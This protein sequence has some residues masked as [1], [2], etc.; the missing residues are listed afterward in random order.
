MHRRSAVV[1]VVAAIAASLSIAWPATST[2]DDQGAVG[3]GRANAITRT[4]TS[5][6]ITDEVFD[7][8]GPE[9][10]GIDPAATVSPLRTAPIEDGAIA[11]STG[12]FG[13]QR[14]TPGGDFALPTDRTRWPD[15]TADIAGVRFDVKGG[16]VDVTIRFTSMPSRDA[17]IAT[18]TFAT[19][20]RPAG[21]PRP[22]PAGAGLR[23]PW[24]AALTMG[25]GLGVLSGGFAAPV[26]VG[27]HTLRTSV[28]LSA[29]P[30]RPWTVAVGAGLADPADPARYWSVPAGVPLPDRP[31]A[32]GQ[33]AVAV[34]DV[35][36]VQSEHGPSAE[37]TQA[38]L[39]ATADVTPTLTRIGTPNAP[40]AS[41]PIAGTYT[42]N[43]LSRWD[44]GDGIRRDPSGVGELGPPP[45]DVPLA[46]PGPWTGWTYTGRL[47]HYA[48][49]VPAS[50]RADAPA[51]LLVYLHGSGGDVT[52][53][54]DAFPDFVNELSARGFLVAAPLGR[55]DTFYRA[56]PGELDVL[57]AIA[58]VRAHHNVDPDRIFL[59]G[60]SGGSAGVNVLT[61]RH[62]DLFAGAVSVVAT[63]EE[64]T[65][66]DNIAGVPWLGITGEADPVSQALDGPGLHQALSDRGGDATL[67]R[68][69][70][71]THEFSLLYDSIPTIV[72]FL[73][74]Q[75]RD[76][77]PPAITWVTK[78]GDARPELGL[79]RGGPW[80]LDGVEPADPSAAAR[81]RVQSF[82]LGRVPAD[83]AMAV[84]SETATVETGR[85]GRA[86]ARVFTT[87]PAA[88]GAGTAANRIELTT[89]N[90]RAARVD[91]PATGLTIDA[92][93]T[94]VANADDALQ[95][96]LVG[97]GGREIGVAVPAG[98]Q[99]VVVVRG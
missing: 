94:V 17:Q 55:G 54:F 99:H 57:E 44:G 46:D 59:L 16:A 56:G 77:A 69:A 73:T 19:A 90:V 23:G 4:G 84:R 48:L 88:A 3:A 38:S 25:G 81:V 97:D 8:N 24:Q 13:A 58:D 26:T 87:R 42:R 37:R 60:F 78:P 6:T 21:A 80:W 29:L 86:I 53:P 7:A 36:G 34:W 20:D 75:R 92:P 22:W 96:T 32:R 61:S 68:Y 47:Q 50:Y 33:T 31:G 30:A 35:V 98:T 91:V 15:F 41:A 28:P 82:G 45:V 95:L 27:D 93:L 83:P 52:E 51:P 9:L 66:V 65:L 14:A 1:A 70:A 63:F 72:D 43:F 85:S 67:V 40:H 39:L 18:V 71:K 10:D 76:P 89:T 62:P 12:V 49:H 2:P 5:W 64:P 74:R 11:A 79:D